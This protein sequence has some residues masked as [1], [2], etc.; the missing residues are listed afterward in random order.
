MAWGSEKQLAITQM[1]MMQ[2]PP[3]TVDMRGLRGCMI[4]CREQ[5]FLRIYR[6]LVTLWAPCCMWHAAAPP[7][8]LRETHFTGLREHEGWEMHGAVHV[9]GVIAGPEP[10][11]RSTFCVTLQQDS[12][13][14]NGEISVELYALYIWRITLGNETIIKN[15][16][17]MSCRWSLGWW[18]PQYFMHVVLSPIVNTYLIKL[19]NSPRVSVCCGT[20]QD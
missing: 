12:R 7:H 5:W 15:R 11:Q 20:S 8:L 10:E 2:I 4:T 3:F 1:M 13:D 9:L 18:S 16:P 17:I 14:C 6:V 19:Y